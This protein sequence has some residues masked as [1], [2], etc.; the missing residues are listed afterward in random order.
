MSAAH[1][2]IGSIGT[3]IS[4]LIQRHFP[5][6][7]VRSSFWPVEL[8]AILSILGFALLNFIERDIARI[9]EVLL[10]VATLICAF[11]IRHRDE[12]A[13]LYLVMFGFLAWMLGINAWVS[14][15]HPEWGDAY[16]HWHFAR[17]YLK[18]F[19]FLLVGWWVGGSERT[20]RTILVAALLGLLG[21]VILDMGPSVIHR[22]ANDSRTAFGFRNAQHS[23]ALFG[24]ALMGVGCLGPRWCHEGGSRLARVVRGGLCSLA[25][26]V[27]F[28]ALLVAQTRAI[29][30][31]LGVCVIA[32]AIFWLK[33]LPNRR[34]LGRMALCIL[35]LVGAIG[36]LA[37]QPN[38]PVGKTWTRTVH[39]WHGARA[40][41]DDSDTVP[42]NSITVRLTE[43]E[44]AIHWIAQRPLFGY[45]GATKA[46]LIRHSEMP[47]FIRH[48]F[49]H[50]HN[51]YLELAVGYGLP[52]LM[53]FVGILLWLARRLTRAWRRGDV[54]GD[55]ALFGL[56]WLTYFAV[57]NVFESYVTYLSGYYQV[58]VAGGVIYGVTMRVKSGHCRPGTL[59]KSVHRKGVPKESG[60][61]AKQC[62]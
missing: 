21:S 1:L 12:S 18:I 14:V 48:H 7:Y 39:Q 47:K 9:A 19:Y 10:A 43:W 40:L 4:D 53:C 26:I 2:S 25:A 46:Y 62:G 37:S 5:S 34:S 42:M 57:I 16:W 60:E 33:R 35:V 20:A 23:A 15:V 22:I 56:G 59:V 61:G 30:I 27:S 55:F 44:S 41:L 58:F 52:A 32:F 6:K 36:A 3:S 50:L 31:A 51:S 13:W 38:N 54:R 17:S 11:Q 24:P 49:G 45:G 28:T 8:V 29:W